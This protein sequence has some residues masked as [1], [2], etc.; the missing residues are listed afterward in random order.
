[1]GPAHEAR[2]DG[3]GRGTFLP[4][5]AAL[6]RLAASLF[7]TPTFTRLSFAAMNRLDA[8]VRD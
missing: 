6:R 8:I 3:E 4:C 7:P 2:D 5:R 1:M